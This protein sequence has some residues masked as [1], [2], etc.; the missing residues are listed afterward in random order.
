MSSI[1]TDE[2]N[3]PVWPESVIVIKPEYSAEKVKSMT[4]KTEDSIK[5]GAV[6]YEQ[7]DS[8]EIIYNAERHFVEDRYAILFEPG[9]YKGIDLEVGYYSQVLGLGA[10]ASDV[11]FSGCDNGP[12]VPALRK[13]EKVGGRPGLSLDSFWRAAENFKNEARKGQLWAVSQAAPMRRVHVTGDLLLHD[14]GAQASGGHLATAIVDGKIQ[15]GSQQQFCCRSVQFSDKVDKG[16]LGAWSNV[17]VDCINAPDA[18]DPVTAEPYGEWRSN[19]AVSVH[20]PTLTVEKPIVVLREDGKYELHVPFPRTREE[21]SGPLEP[22]VTG[23]A[24]KSIRPFERVK[25]AVSNKTNRCGES[26]PDLDVAKEINAAL[27][28][29]KDIVLTPG[30]YYLSETLE[31]SQPNQVILGIGLATLIAPTDGSPII[32]VAPRTEGVR[33][34][35]LMLEASVLKDKDP[36]TVATFIQWGDHGCADK[37]PGNPDMPGAM[38]DIFARVGGSNL[39]RTVSTNIMVRIDSGNVYGDNLWLW[40]ADHVKLREGEEP[41]VEGLDY[42]QVLLGECPCET[43]LEVNGDDVTIHGLA[44]E[45]T[46]QTNTIWNGERGEVMFYQNEL[47]YDVDSTYAES[48]YVGYK[49]GDHVTSH[50]A[51]G[52]GVYSNFRD[53]EVHVETGMEHP[54]TEEGVKIVNPFSVWLNNKGFIKSVS[55]GKGP[56]LEKK[57]QRG[58]FN[59]VDGLLQG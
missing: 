3:P 30:L 55:N 13:D 54:M 9:T 44:V 43:G 32:H 2:I 24:K 52:V 16:Q 25:V 57:S 23:S 48:K 50:H 8:G 31:I 56:A 10:A 6:N 37:D 38:T 29:G 51:Q 11:V 22:D 33:L 27:R 35:G 15:F 12:Y 47:P 49:V 53:Y 14:A 26:V 42:H 59:G 17:F 21:G 34:A 46:T 41:N 28:E 40:R 18:R 4:A 19:P 36:D 39:D 1:S 45:H 58:R 20:D 5:E 7:P